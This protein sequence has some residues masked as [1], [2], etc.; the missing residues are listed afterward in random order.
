MGCDA[1]R[2]PRDAHQL[3][4]LPRRGRVHRRGLRRVGAG[5]LRGARRGRGRARRRGRGPR[6]SGGG[7]WSAA[8]VRRLRRAARR[9]AGLAPDGRVRGELDVLLVGH[10]GPAQGGE[11]PAGRRGARRRV[12]VQHAGAGALR[13]RRGQRLP[14]PGAALPRRPRRLDHGVPP[15][16]R[17][18]GRHGALRP[19]R[20]AG[21]DRAAPR[22]PRAVRAHPP[23]AADEAAGRGP[24]AVRPLQPPRSSC[25]RPRRARPT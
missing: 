10:H 9:P 2:A 13:R 18:H 14:Q 3:A 21:P 19:P 5:G 11:A 25:T 1:H 4:P 24:G 7:R 12:L 23:R 16:G 17:H 20:G 22:D 6:R 15:P 8:G